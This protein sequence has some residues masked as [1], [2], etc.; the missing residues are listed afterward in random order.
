MISKDKSGIL[1]G[2][3]S[4]LID[5]NLKIS[6]KGFMRLRKASVEFDMEIVGKEFLN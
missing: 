3:L 5:K 1:G 4:T 2:L 6:Y